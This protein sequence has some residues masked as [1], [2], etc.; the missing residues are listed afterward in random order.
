MSAALIGCSVTVRPWKQRLH[1]IGA[2]ESAGLTT[3]RASKA[4]LNSVMKDASL[5]HGP[6]GATCIAMHPGWVKTDMGGAGADLDVGDSAAGIRRT[7]AGLSHDD[8]GGFFNY[9]GGAI[10]W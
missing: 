9:D 6:Q 2:R 1:A 7:I 5:V 4:A 3:Y 8:N 10:R